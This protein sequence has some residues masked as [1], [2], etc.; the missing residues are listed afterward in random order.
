MAFVLANKLSSRTLLGTQLM[1]LISDAY[2]DDKVSIMFMLKAACG[3][4]ALTNP[5]HVCRASLRHAQPTSRLSL[6][7]MRPATNTYSVCC[8]SRAFRPSRVTALPTGFGSKAV[9]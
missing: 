5:Q 2:A 4:W 1:R 9:G 3:T 6:S 8:T 7:A